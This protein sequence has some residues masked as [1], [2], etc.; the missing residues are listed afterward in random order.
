M[1]NPKD[2]CNILFVLSGYLIIEG[3][4]VILKI[5]KYCIRIV[6]F[7]FVFLFLYLKCVFGS[8]NKWEY[9]IL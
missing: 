3:K 1:W 4:C 5:L 7:N 6:V 8:I 9:F 2:E